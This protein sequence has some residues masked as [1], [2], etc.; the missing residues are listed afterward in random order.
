M[1]AFSL[2]PLLILPAVL[3]AVLFVPMGGEGVREALA[4]T[5]ATAPLASGAE[6][7][8]SWG[9]A[10]T[11]LTVLCLFVE[12]LKSTRPTRGAL[13][14]NALSVLVF[15]TCLIL[16]L[17]TPGFGTTEFFFVV[18]MSLLDFLAGSVVMVVASRRTVDYQA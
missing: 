4:A 18:V 2:F 3:Y 9:Q 6:W 13:A 1:R 8:V 12:I 7:V 17:L 10:F 14:D 15:V 5:A 16:F 11:L